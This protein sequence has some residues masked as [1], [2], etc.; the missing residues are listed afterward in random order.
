MRTPAFAEV[1]IDAVHR[2][3]DFEDVLPGLEQQQVGA[4]FDQTAGL[5]AEEIGELVKTDAAEIGIIARGQHAAGTH[6][7]GDEAGDAGF[8]FALD[9]RRRA[10][11]GRPR[12]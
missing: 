3:L 5:F 8:G 2:R 9:H 6:A 11:C 1:A 4:A 12:D 7:A 10:R